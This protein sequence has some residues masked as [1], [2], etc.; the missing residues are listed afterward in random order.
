MHTVIYNYDF[1]FPYRSLFE[2]KLQLM[3][4]LYPL[5][6]IPCIVS[7]MRLGNVYCDPLT[8]STGHKISTRQRWTPTPMQ[9]QILEHIFDQGTG[10]PSKQKIKD[11][12]NELTQ[13]GP[14]SE[15]N[16]YNWFQNRRARSKRKQHGS[17]PNNAES[18]VETEVESP[19]EKRG[20]SENMQ[21]NG[22]QAMREDELCFQSSER[23]SELHAMDPQPGKGESMFP[24]DGC[25]KSS[26]NLGDISF[27]DSVLSNPSMY[28]L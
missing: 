21:S 13:H 9:L 16:V 2:C 23:S 25:P 22:N 7:G 4:Y 24:S 19:R 15:T 5:M 14:I 11:I 18:E 8:I 1:S 10:T 27:Y 3:D 26:G 12:T 28:T 20:K 17:A 6:K